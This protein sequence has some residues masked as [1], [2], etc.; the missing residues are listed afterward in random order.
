MNRPSHPRPWRAL[1]ALGLALL[2]AAC[3]GAPPRPDA[4]Q[5]PQAEAALDP[6]TTGALAQFES[7]FAARIPE[8]E[9]SGLKLLPANRE[10]LE[11]RF[12]PGGF[13]YAGNAASDLDVW[14]G[15]RR[16]IVVN[17]EASVARRAAQVAT[18]ESVYPPR[19]AS[20]SRWARMLRLHQWLKNLLL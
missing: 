11:A 2:L 7:A 15:A 10:A 8:P 20:P 3:A 1:A 5:R 17:A 12:G 9:T 14:A 4:A 13:D 16:A 6:A 18:V 19:S